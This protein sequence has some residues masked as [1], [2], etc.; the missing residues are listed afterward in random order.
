MRQLNLFLTAGLLLAAPLAYATVRLPA[1]VGSHMV[2]QRG[3]PVPVWGWAAPGEKVSIA[4]RG[5]AYAAGLPDA[6]GRWQATLPAMPAGGPYALTI[7]GQ[8]T[9]ELTDVLMGDVWL[10]SGQSNM[11]M[12]VQDRS[13]GY[14][15]VQNADQEIAAANWPNI[16]FFTAQQTVAY[17]PQ[18]EVAGSGW[19]VCSPATVAQLSAVAYFFGRDLYKKY[20]VPVGLLVS[21][22]GGTPAEAW[23][24]A[25]GL[26]AFPEFGPRVADFASRTTS[27]TDD[28]QAY[29]TRQRELM[30][31]IRQY[32][33]GYLPSG[34]TWAAPAFDAHAWPTMPVPGI[35][36]SA[37]GLATYDGVVWFRKE[38]DL[39]ASMAGQPLTLALGKIDDAD[40]TYVNGVRVGATNGYQLA[41]SYP[42]PAGL[43][44]PGRNVIAV[45]VVDTGGGGGITG[46]PG[47]VALRGASQTLPLAGAW[48]YQVGLAPQDQ[49]A[50][51]VPG[52]AEH[53]PTTLYNGMIAPLQPYALK[54]VIWYQG[55]SNAD[56]AAQ[57]RTLFPALIADWRRHRQQPDLPFLWVQLA[58]YMAA[59][60]QPAESAWAE[61]R[62]AQ[63]LALQVPH[64]GLATAIDIGEAND[65]HPHNKQ[66]VGRRLALAAEHAAYGDNNVLYSGPQYASMAPAGAAVRLKFSHVGA[67]LAV[68]NGA[69]LQGFAVAGADHKFH[70]ATA[71]VVGNEV[72]VQSPA[73]PQPVAVRYDWADNPNGNLTNKESLPALPFR[74]DTWPLTT[75]GRN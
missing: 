63:A 25:E 8:N 19:L 20:Q 51:P 2:L 73:V 68:K 54:G 67:G 42:V 64:T 26:A 70:W 59:L 43:L 74:T 56:R 21:S 7:K 23:V 37:P 55:E 49:P 75:A 66:E 38:I 53:A 12:P 71:R 57:Y 1:L 52:G 50:P 30:R 58:S 6:S 24:S 33:K 22:W 10:A 27:L 14:Q 31:N 11:Q 4:F 39:P 72:E 5:K 48:Q 17:R 60:P 3:R 40:S 61:L 36:E 29:E 9:I 18:A 32:D 15:P 47:E 41:R 34:Q 13:G 69:A 65:I 28:Q 35:W 46:E 62:E 45:R 44:R 16:H